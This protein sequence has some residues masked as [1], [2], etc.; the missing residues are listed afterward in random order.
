MGHKGKEYATKINGHIRAILGLFNRK[1]YLGYTATPFAN[2]LQ[3]KNEAPLSKWTISYSEKGEKK[4]KDF[5]MVPNLFPED[6]IELLYPPSVYVGAK[7]F[8][9]T[10]IDEIKK[11][12][13]LIPPPINDHLN[14]FPSRIDVEQNIPTNSFGKGT[15]AVNKD[16]PYPIIFQ[17]H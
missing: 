10:R 17:N 7:H 4:D 3:D 12:E 9:E 14:S 11:I 8:F 1:T 15:R 16:D 5:T 6:F 13:P 2:V